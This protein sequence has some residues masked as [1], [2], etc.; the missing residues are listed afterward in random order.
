MKAIKNVKNEYSLADQLIKVLME[1]TIFK[2]IHT[3]FSE[4]YSS[5]IIKYDTTTLYDV[6]LE[7]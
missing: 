2:E 3:K 4:H 1:W 7:E 5:L 6:T